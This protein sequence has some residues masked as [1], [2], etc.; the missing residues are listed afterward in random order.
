MKEAVISTVSPV[1][2]RSAVTAQWAS[3]DDQ[4]TRV[5]RWPKRMWRSM[6]P[7]LAVSRT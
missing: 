4:A 3:G 7:S 2:V 5:T 1:S 6:P